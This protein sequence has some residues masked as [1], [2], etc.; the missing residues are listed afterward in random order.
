MGPHA[1]TEADALAEAI[2]AHAG[3]K[4]GGYAADDACHQPA[5]DQDQDRSQD[6][7]QECEHVVDHSLD[8]A[9]QAF[10]GQGADDGGQEEQQGQPVG[11]IADGGRDRCGGLIR[12]LITL[13]SSRSSKRLASS[14]RLTKTRAMLATI[15]AIKRRI[16][17]PRS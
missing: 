3:Q 11:R 14:P 13:S 2:N 10:K 1:G 6:V 16:A 5:D 12:R 8:R 4:A 9:E 17:A 7:W 15:Q